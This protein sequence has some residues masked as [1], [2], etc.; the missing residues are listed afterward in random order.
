MCVKLLETF[1]SAP[2]YWKL[3]GKAHIVG[4]LEGKAE[5]KVGRISRLQMWLSE[6]EK[7]P[8]IFNLPVGRTVRKNIHVFP[9]IV[10]LSNHT[11]LRGLR[12]SLIL[13]K[14]YMIS[15]FQFLYF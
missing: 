7:F 12:T 4:V 5:I 14:W 6:D 11:T 15:V 8:R 3:F 10:A 9:P 13:A 2:G 1:W